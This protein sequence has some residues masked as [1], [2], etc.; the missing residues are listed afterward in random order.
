M[1]VQA[2]VSERPRSVLVLGNFL[3][4]T[5]GTFG[6]CEALAAEL[7]AVGW[8][9]V[10]ASRRPG[11][12]T[13]LIDIMTTIW[14][15]RRRYSV[16]QIDLYSGAAFIWAEAACWLLDRL[17]V[18]YVLTLHGGNLP[19]FGAKHRARVSRL[20]RRAV[21]VTTPS[22]FLREAMAPFRSDLIL[23]PNGIRTEQYPFRLR[24][25]PKP[26]LLWVRA[27]HEIYNPAMAVRVVD[28]LR[29]DYPE[30]HLTLV[31]PDREDGTRERTIEM[32]QQLGLEEH[33]EFRGAVPKASLPRVFDEHDIFLNTSSV[34]NAPVTVI[35]AMA[36]GL[37]VVSTSAGGIAQLVT[38]QQDALLV[39]PG[40]ADAMSAAVRRLL[41]SV[42]LAS[43]LSTSGRENAV[44]R[45]WATVLP[46]WE[47]ILSAAVSRGHS[48]RMLNPSRA[49]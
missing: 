46:R 22:P 31:G 30:V 7:S 27:F 12:V 2:R 39:R 43:L 26:R 42:E 8:D 5:T 24:T 6:V 17:H 1:M 21:A 47:E 9:V 29:R 34:D 48:S 45:D 28:Q 41:T 33:V 38:D 14:R 37:C 10:C 35:E 40:D 4:D 25:A 11:R 13:R 18:P 3:H 16:A 44:S 15:E 49:A 20:L 19:V 23:Q 32:T 36:G